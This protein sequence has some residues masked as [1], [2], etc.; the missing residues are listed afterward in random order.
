[1]TTPQTREVTGAWLTAGG[2]LAG[3]APSWLAPPERPARRGRWGQLATAP[4]T[5]RGKVR[6]ADVTR[7]AQSPPTH[8]H[9]G[10]CARRE[11]HGR[12]GTRQGRRCVC[13]GPRRPG[14]G[15]RPTDTGPR[16]PA[17]PRGRCVCGV[18][19]AWLRA[20]PRPPRQRPREA[21]A[22]LPACVGLR[23]QAPEVAPDVTV[24]GIAGF[25]F[26]FDFCFVEVCAIYKNHTRL[27]RI[28]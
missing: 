23:H 8:T 16:A 3:I 1:M 15:H 10:L 21:P 22:L 5:Q 26:F 27:T 9:Q 24:G 12:E 14:H 7:G 19:L 4:T 28:S 2:S 17:R 18:A 13:A 11:Q 25:F 20:L 6:F